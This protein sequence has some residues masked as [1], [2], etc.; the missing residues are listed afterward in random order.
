M[1]RREDVACCVVPDALRLLD[2][3][4]T[5]LMNIAGFYW[6]SHHGGH[7][8]VLTQCRINVACCAACVA[9]GNTIGRHP[10]RWPCVTMRR[11]AIYPTSIAGET[12]A[13]KCSGDVVTIVNETALPDIVDTLF[14]TR[15]K[16]HRGLYFLFAARAF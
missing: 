2:C 8:A 1:R 16:I 4:F 15:L 14:Q 5:C 12:F 6:L 10:A 9:E 11:A 13:V 7:E 3:G